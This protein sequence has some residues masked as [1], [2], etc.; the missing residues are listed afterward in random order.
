MRF[1]CGGGCFHWGLVGWLERGR[2][3]EMDGGGGGVERE[4]QAGEE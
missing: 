4:V 3:G 1:V 2:G